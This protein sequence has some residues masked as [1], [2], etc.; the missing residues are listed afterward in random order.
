MTDDVRREASEL[1]EQFGRPA[2]H[3]SATRFRPQW[4]N[5]QL[6]AWS[7]SHPSFKTQLFRFVDVF[8]A[9]R[10][11]VDVLRHLEEYLEE[12]ELPKMLDYTLSPR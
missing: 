6:L 10:D 8:P 1:A 2:V 9:T 7:V 12:A 11:D 3:H 5:E 4:W